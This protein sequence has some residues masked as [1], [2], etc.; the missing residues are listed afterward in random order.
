MI[1]FTLAIL[2]AIWLVLAIFADKD[3]MLNSV[4]WLG[5]AMFAGW[6]MVSLLFIIV[7]QFCSR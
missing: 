6:L 1:T 3:K 2:L 5:W 7:I 4:S